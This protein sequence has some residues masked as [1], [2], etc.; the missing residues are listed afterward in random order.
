MGDSDKC[1]SLGDMLTSSGE[2]GSK[3]ISGGDPT[4]GGEPIGD[5]EPVELSDMES[6]LCKMTNWV[7]SSG[8]MD[9]RVRARVQW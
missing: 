6:A 3:A 7:T 8:E 5:K 4:G 2:D 1:E 9:G